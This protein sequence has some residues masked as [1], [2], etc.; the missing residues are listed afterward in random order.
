M[1]EASDPEVRGSLSATQPSQ[2]LALRDAPGHEG[3]R[4]RA[5]RNCK[6]N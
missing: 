5:N 2:T 3:N 1:T 4:P 6:F